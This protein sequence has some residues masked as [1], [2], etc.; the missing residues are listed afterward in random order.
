MHKIKA[1]YIFDLISKIQVHHKHNLRNENKYKL[2]KVSISRYKQSLIYQGLYLW[3]NLPNTLKMSPNY[4]V[5]KIKMI[6]G[7]KHIYLS[8]IQQALYQIIKSI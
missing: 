7:N 2:P 6:F 1:P 5:F 8:I 3:N 4:N